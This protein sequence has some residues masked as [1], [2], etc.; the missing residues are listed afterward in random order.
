MHSEYL[1]S[2]TICR[3]LIAGI[4][5]SRKYKSTTLSDVQYKSKTHLDVTRIEYNHMHNLFEYLMLVVCNY[6]DILDYQDTYVKT[7]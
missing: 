2:S 5:Y 4:R 7:Y 3:I 1:V 6:Q